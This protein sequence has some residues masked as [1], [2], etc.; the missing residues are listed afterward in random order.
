MKSPS[1][2]FR[3]YGLLRTYSTSASVWIWAYGY[4]ELVVGRA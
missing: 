3:R 1:R 4:G 2:N